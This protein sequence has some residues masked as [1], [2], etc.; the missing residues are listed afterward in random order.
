MSNS[1]P[2]LPRP[3]NERAL[4]Y[5]PGTPERAEIERQLRRASSE[6]HEVPLIV[7]GKEVRTGDLGRCLVPH[8]H[9]QVLATYHRAGEAE[10]ARAIQAAIEAKP[11]WE[12]QPWEQR[13]AVFLKAAE[14]LAG[15]WRQVINAATMLN[16]GKTVHQAEIDAACELT[17]FLRHNAYFASE[18]LAEQPYNDDPSVWNRLDHRPLEGFVFA[19]SPFNFTSIAGNLASSAA[20]L[21]N[22]VVWKP[23]STAVYSGYLLMRLFE[24]AGLPPGVINFVPG[25]GGVVGDAVLDSEHL[26]GVNFTGSTETFNALWKGVAARLDRYRTYPRLV[27]ETGGKNFVFAHPS[28]DVG[29]LV[30]ALVRGAF[31]YQG[32]KCS[33]ASRAYIPESLWGSVCERL[34]EDVATIKCGPVEDFR[35][36]LG[37]VIDRQAFDRI[38]GYIDLARNSADAKIL[39]GGKRDC[40]EGYFIEPTLIVTEDPRFVTM[41]EEIFGPVL[42]L[43]RY[44]GRDLDRA[45]ELCATTSPYGLTGAFFAQDRS[46]IAQAEGVL[47]HSAGMFY[48][49]DKPTGAVVGQ[50]PF[51][52]A[53]ASGT[54]DKAG[55]KS[56]LLRWLSQRTVKESLRPSTDYRYPYMKLV[57]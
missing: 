28:A 42:T 26:A 18:I 40:R 51:G 12:A 19:V 24:A 5:A 20:M 21:G 7:G 30:T 39:A 57:K 8:R 49:N 4:S 34:V 54:N 29:A 25:Q 11:E 15:P 10:V 47:R 43:Y 23:A 22:T 53:R 46:A 41:Q 9:R 52:G 36:F 44:A 50:Q 16:Q 17:D 32:Q 35:C 31:E 45:L 55:G 1:I 33:A 14:L 3:R 38:S 6:T 2:R 37:A 56:Y 48:I 13:V 27:G